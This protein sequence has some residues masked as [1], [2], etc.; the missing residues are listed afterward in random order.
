VQTRTLTSPLEYPFGI[1]RHGFV[2]ADGD[3]KPTSIPILDAVQSEIAPIVEE[4]L[5]R[6]PLL[7]RPVA[8]LTCGSN[9]SPKRL[10]EKLQNAPVPSAI[11]LRVRLENWIPVY[12]ATLS[13]YGSIPAT[14]EYLPNEIAEPFMVIT[15]DLNAQQLIESEQRTGNYDLFTVPSS[16][17]GYSVGFP[18]FAFVCRFGALRIN[19]SVQRLREF[20][21][22]E[23][24]GRTQINVVRDLLED[25]EPALDL[26]QYARKALERE[27]AEHFG[28]RVRTQYALEPT[29][30]GWTRLANKQ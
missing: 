16:S 1:P 15:D 4:T 18:I 29:V 5:D 24:M 8:F 3:L 12:G 25:I 2:I 26:G 20:Q 30:P 10:S 17:L 21:K 23:G 19:G 22:E 6:N 9:A 28:A 27:F 14:F 13:Y 11:A 7:R